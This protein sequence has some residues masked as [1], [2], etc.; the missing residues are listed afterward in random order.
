MH[1]IVKGE[2]NIHKNFLMWKNFKMK[3][4]LMGPSPVKYSTNNS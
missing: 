3:E 2:T 1:K 4:K